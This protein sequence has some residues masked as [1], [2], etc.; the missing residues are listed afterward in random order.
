MPPWQ[1]AFFVPHMNLLKQIASFVWDIPIE[2]TSSPQNDYLEVVW[3]NGR[4]MLN[5]KEANFSFGNGYKVFATAMQ[6]I[7]PQIDT[8]SDILVLG[9]GCGSIHHLLEKKYHYKNTIVGVEYDQEI[10]RLYNEHFAN[11][12]NL[13]PSIYIEDAQQFL[14][15]CQD[16]FDIIFIDLFYELENS[17]LLSD[18][19]FLQ[20]LKNRCTENTTLVFNTTTADSKGESTV[21]ELQLWLSKHFK[22]VS[23]MPFQE[24]NQIIIAQ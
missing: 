1:E 3:S 19:S 24:F 9:F 4:K 17:P 5:T 21:F 2:K 20:S 7:E 22:S 12:Y 14:Q 8:A 6:A 10:V 13:T 23:K 15:R 11:A 18:T 16:T